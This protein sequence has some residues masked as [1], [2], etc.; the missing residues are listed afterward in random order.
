[1]N[2]L[3]Q[4]I[5]LNCDDPIQ[6]IIIPRGMRKRPGPKTRSSNRISTKK[7]RID[8]SEQ[9]LDKGI[10][11]RNKYTMEFKAKLFEHRRQMLELYP[12]LKPE[13]REVSVLQHNC[14]LCFDLITTINCCV[15]KTLDALGSIYKMNYQQ[16]QALLRRYEEKKQ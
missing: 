12:K 14:V 15:F 10:Q 16:V 5:L 7:K 9:E 3:L 6:R 13:G 1:M 2:V 4:K 8:Y 11:H